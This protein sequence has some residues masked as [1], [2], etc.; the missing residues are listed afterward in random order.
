MPFQRGKKLPAIRNLILQQRRP[1]LG[2]WR[3]VRGL[4]CACRPLG[5]GDP[6]DPLGPDYDPLFG[7][8]VAPGLPNPNW[9]TP[10][11][12]AVSSVIV[13]AP[14]AIQLQT[15]STLI[16][17]TAQEYAT[18]IPYAGTGLTQFGLPSAAPAGGI[19]GV[20][21][22]NFTNVPA[23]A[24]TIST[25]GIPSSVSAYLPYLVLGLGGIALI[26]VLKRR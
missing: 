23:P 3:T 20:P 4:G 19:P 15:A 6:T 12:D 26:S 8:P 21:A 11:P 7:I 24:T 18:G 9:N 13:G 10:A 16:P 1:G 14:T 17:P 5:Q 25:T 2:R 22:L